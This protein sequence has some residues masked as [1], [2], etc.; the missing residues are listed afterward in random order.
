M[1]EYLDILDKSGTQTGESR[2][3]EEAHQ[4]GLIHKAVHVWIVNSENQILIQKRE[5]NRRAYP[6]HWDIS[7]AGHVSAGETSREAGKREAKEELGIVLSDSDC[8]PLGT[9]EEHIILNEGTYI[10]NEFQDVFIVRKDISIAEITI[11]PEEVEEVRWISIE[12]FQK[13]IDGKGELMVPHTQEQK[14]LLEYLAINK[15]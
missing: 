10:N 2:T 11:D 13:W 5:K 3:Y 12:E 1:A 7:S 14:R 8:I 4:L 6:S 15:A 9:F